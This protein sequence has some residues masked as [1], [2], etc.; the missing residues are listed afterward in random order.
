MFEQ[1]AGKGRLRWLAVAQMEEEEGVADRGEQRKK[2][3]MLCANCWDMFLTSQTLNLLK[4][5]NPAHYEPVL[6]I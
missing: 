2:K 3:V 1:H 6:F 4:K 5:E